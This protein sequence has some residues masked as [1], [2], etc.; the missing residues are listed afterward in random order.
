M[1]LAF[2]VSHPIQYYAPLHRLLAS[3]SK[4]AIKVFF[5]WHGGHEAVHDPG[6]G[7]RLAWDIL[8]TDG[9]EHEVVPNVSS[10]PGTHHFWGLRNPG[11]PERLLAWAPDA[12]HVTGYAYASH[13]QLLRALARRKIPVL[14]RGDSHLLDGRHGWRW[15]F[16]RAALRRIYAWPTAFLCVGKANRAYYRACRVPES[17]LFP[18][19]HSIEVDRFAQPHETLETQ[20]QIWRRELGLDPQTRVLLF[21][22]KFEPKKQP[23]ELMDACASWPVGDWRLLLVGDGELGDLVR[24]RASANPNRFQVLP[25]QN[26]SRMPVVYRLGNIFVLPSAYQE[27]WGLA[28][29]EALACGRPV[30]VSDRVGCAADVV[31]QGV[32]GEVFRAGNWADCRAAYERLRVKPT[33]SAAGLQASARRFDIP[34]TADHLMAALRQVTKAC[35]NKG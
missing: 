6:F 26:Q 33:A 28:V 27:T 25:F 21:V 13:L 12:V 3:R 18:C 17:R 34:V 11:L 23:L 29:N 9:Y 2:V 31:E 14:F 32:N 35:V 19:P 8:L 20:A 4:L 10:D 1:R 7:K 30:L 15:W 5:T 24:R 22:G 16:T